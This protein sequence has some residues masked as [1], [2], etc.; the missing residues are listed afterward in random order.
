MRKVRI[1]LVVDSEP[2]ARDILE[3]FPRPIVLDVKLGTTMTKKER[4]IED[5]LREGHSSSLH[6]GPRG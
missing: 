1:E 5:P 6:R 2:Q 3:N 4:E